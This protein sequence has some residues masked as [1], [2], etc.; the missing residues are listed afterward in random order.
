MALIIMEVLL[1][2]NF[3]V[4]GV[5]DIQTLRK[6]SNFIPAKKIEVRKNFQIAVIK[7]SGRMALKH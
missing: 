3:F 5:F 1:F 6:A 2:I 4:L 7:F